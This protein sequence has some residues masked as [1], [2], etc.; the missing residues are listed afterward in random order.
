MI[1][2]ALRITVSIYRSK[3]Q[4]QW[5]HIHRFE[6]MLAWHG[7]R[8]ETEAALAVCSRKAQQQPSL[9]CSFLRQLASASSPS[10]PNPHHLST[11][12][13]NIGEARRNKGLSSYHL[14]CKSYQKLKDNEE[15]KI[16]FIRNSIVFPY[17]IYL[18]IFAVRLNTHGAA[19]TLVF[20]P[21]EAPSVFM[22]WSKRISSQIRTIFFPWLQK[23]R[24]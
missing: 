16:I 15:A 6:E 5:L 14:W 20:R 9:W 24:A 21:T 18:T 13:N 17:I 23:R 12:L 7:E 22:R 19:F 3:P 1:N 8:G 2:L 4:Y 11:C 10:P